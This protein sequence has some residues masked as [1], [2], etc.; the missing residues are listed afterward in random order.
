MRDQVQLTQLVQDARRFVMYHKGAIESYP[1][2]TYVSAL[3]F[4]STGSLIRQQFQHEETKEIT[5]KPDMSETWSACLQ[6]LE[7]HSSG[8]NSVAFSHDSIRLASASHDCTVKIWNISS[9]A[10]VQTLEGHRDD[11]K[12]VAFSHDSTQLASA[13]RDGTIKIWDQN[14]GMCLQTLQDHSDAVMSVC[15]S[16]D[17]TQLASASSD[18]TVKIW[19]ISNGACL[20]TLASHSDDVSSVAFSHD[21]AQ[22]ASRCTDGTMQIWD[23]S[24]GECLQ[25]LKVHNGEV[26]SAHLIS[27]LASLQSDKTVTKPQQLVFQRAATSSDFTWISDNARNL[28]WLP[29]EFR[30]SCAALSGRCVGLGTGTGKVWTCRF[31]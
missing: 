15:Y 28:L 31:L 13:S 1:L 23:A 7:G 20:Q 29:T 24:N 11:V 14:S 22:L 4:S 18:K 3:L 26:S 17:S 12:S 25:T 16:H 27:I 10:C 30:P 9:G 19:D 21:S 6:T 2:Q 8:V 5:I